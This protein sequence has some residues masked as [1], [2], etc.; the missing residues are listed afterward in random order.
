MSS[1]SERHSIETPEQIHIEFTVAGVGTRALALIIDSLIQGACGL[2]LML[3]LVLIGISL[4]PA[5]RGSLT[6][7]VAAVILAGFLL[8][9]G[10][11]IVFE[12]LWNGQTPGKRRIGIRVIKDTGRRLTAL[13]TVARNL[14]RIVDQ[15]PGFY[16]IGILASVMNKQNKRIGDLVAGALV[17]REASPQ[18]LKRRWYVEDR[19]GEP[20]IPLGAE[21]L[22]DEDLILVESFLGRRFELDPDTRSRMAS[23]IFSRLESKLTVSDRDR[24]GV[25]R[26]LETVVAERRG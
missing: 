4:R 17:I 11:F 2:V 8:Y 10:Y 18:Q 13:E 6:W 23:Q 20:G 24:A 22:S 14:L 9:Y 5:V 21:R 1:F 3:V 16:A 12:I 25:E 7:A 19:A 15:L 26:L